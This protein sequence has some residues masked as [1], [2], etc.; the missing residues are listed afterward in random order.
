MLAHSFRSQ[1]LFFTMSNTIKQRIDEGGFALG[2]AAVVLICF[3]LNVLDGFDIIA[4]SVVAPILAGEWGH[5]PK[6]SGFV[7]S[8]ALFGMTMGAVFLAPLC[9][10]YG[11]RFMILAA[12]LFTGICMLLTTQIPASIG[13]LIT[14]RVLTGLGIGV[15]MASTTAITSEFVPERWRNLCVPLVVLGYPFGAMLVGP[16]A[17]ALI[18]GYGWEAMFYFGGG[19]TLLLAALMFILLPESI[20]YL[21]SRSGRDAWRLTRINQVLS[22]LGR[23]SINTLPPAADHI[24]SASVRTLLQPEFRATSI[25]LWIIS[26][27]SLLNMYFLFTWLP[28]LFERSGLSRADGSAAL[29]YFNLGGVLGIV[30]IGIISSRFYLLKPIT[31]FFSL[32][33]VVMLIYAVLE[34]SD[35]ALLNAL[36]FTVGLL[37]QGGYTGGSYSVP[38]RAYPPLIRATGVGWAIGLGRTGAI[39]APVLTGY[40]VSFGWDMYSLFALFSMPILLVTL[41]VSSIKLEAD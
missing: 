28:S 10:K 8:A 33:A 25:K 17:Q 9:D 41:L 35:I 26:F 39:V 12:A 20:V 24:K 18:P 36:I 23:A 34:S 1:H 21:A 4:M 2:Q 3:M 22:R 30:L 27:C 16:I 15:I 32:S 37:F 14:I 7:L 31:W 29:T 38:A 11:R 40:L 19:A 6:Q 13:W 5:S